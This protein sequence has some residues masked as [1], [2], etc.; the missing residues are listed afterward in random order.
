MDDF[1]L[2]DAIR[3]VRCR[4]ILSTIHHDEPIT[5]DLLADKT[6]TNGCYGKVRF[7]SHE[8]ALTRMNQFRSRPATL[9]PYHCEH[10]G[11]W[12]LGNHK[13]RGGRNRSCG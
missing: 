9:H 6:F 8:A 12:H 3:C 11:K 7:D 10:C 5:K 1:S 2:L 4:T 13:Q